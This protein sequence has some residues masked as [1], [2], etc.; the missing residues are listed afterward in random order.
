[1]RTAE[2]RPAESVD[3]ADHRI[4]RVEKAPALRNDRARE[5]DG[6]DVE[7]HLHDER[8]EVAH[9]AIANEERREPDARAEREDHAEQENRNR[10]DDVAAEAH[11]IPEH[12][13]EQQRRGDCKVDERT[14][15]CG[16]WND[17]TWKVDL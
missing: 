5:S 8:D 4:E 10:P 6:R 14:D 7:A 17:E 15:R 12:Q 13:D 9:V 2:K 1:M 3:H 11:A 16:N